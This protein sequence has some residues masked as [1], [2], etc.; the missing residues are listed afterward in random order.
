MF[1]LKKFIGE[2]VR[3]RRLSVVMPD[4]E[5]CEVFCIIESIEDDM[6]DVLAASISDLTFANTDGEKYAIF[7]SEDSVLS[8]DIVSG[9]GEETGFLLIP[10]HQKHGVNEIKHILPLRNTAAFVRL[11]SGNKQERIKQALE[12]D[13]HIQEQIKKL[14]ERYLGYDLSQMPLYWGNTVFVCYNPIFKSI[15]LTED[16]KNKGLYFRVNYRRGHKEPL[17]VD[18]VGKAKDG[19]ILQEY[20]Y[21]TEEGVFLSH[22]QFKENYPFI[23]IDVRTMDGTLV[24]YYRDVAFIHKISVNVSMKGEE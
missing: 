18:I 8:S 23:D 10:L 6:Q 12:N 3:H 1:E 2:K 20:S 7:E 15:D 24:D 19:A 21:K 5:R 17:M 14:S 9:W 13:N 16:G 22:F 11:Y 4:N